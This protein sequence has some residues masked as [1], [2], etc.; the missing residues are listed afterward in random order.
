MR[1]TLFNTLWKPSGRWGS[2]GTCLDA[3]AGPEVAGF[4]RGHLCC[5]INGSICHFS[6]LNID[7]TA[8]DTNYNILLSSH[9]YI[10]MWRWTHTWGETAPRTG[11]Q[12]W[13]QWSRTLFF[14]VIIREHECDGYVYI[15]LMKTFFV[16]HLV[17]LLNCGTSIS[18]LCSRLQPSFHIFHQFCAD[19]NRSNL[20]LFSHSGNEEGRRKSFVSLVNWDK[21]PFCRIVMHPVVMAPRSNS[22]SKPLYSVSLNGVSKG[23]T[24]GCE[25]RKG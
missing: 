2:T 23:E 25:R 12:I 18:H 10:K 3:K 13:S 9:V 4:A 17:Q 14:G 5:W 8:M 22:Y 20:M 15:F 19:V 1:P 21:V 6:S 16:L 11:V 24:C 7:I